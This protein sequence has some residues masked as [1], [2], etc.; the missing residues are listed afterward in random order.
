MV[1]A[2]PDG[3]A[4]DGAEIVVRLVGPFAVL[5]AGVAVAGA[6]LG[7]R[8]ARLLVKLLAVERGHLVPVNRIVDL[9]WVDEP[10]PRS[11]VENVATLVSRL[12]KV[13]GAAVVEGGRDEGY[14]LGRPPAVLVDLDEAE[15]W[16]GQA[17]ARLAAGEAG[18]AVAA[19]DRA[20]DLTASGVALEDEPDARWAEP[21][22]EQLISLL[23]KG[24]HVLA[25]AGLEAGDARRAAAVA[26]VAV[27]ADPYDEGACRLLMRALSAL[28]EPSR[29]LAVYAELRDRLAD[30]LGADPAAETR[31][32]HLGLLREEAPPDPAGPAERADPADPAASAVPGTRDRRRRPRVRVGDGAE[33]LGLVGRR[34]ELRSLRTRWNAAAAGTGSMVLVA[35]E[36][37]IGKTRLCQELVAIAAATGGTALQARCHEAE[38]SLFL[39]PVVD[40]VGAA[41]RTLP[42]DVTREATGDAVDSLASL[43]PDAVVVLGR[44]SSTARSSVQIEHRRAFEAV[45]GFVRR[46]AGRGPV[47]LL[48]DDLHLAGRETVQLLHYLARHCSASRLLVVAT[49]RAE[50][51]QDVFDLLADVGVRLD[52]PALPPEAVSQLAEAAGQAG[53]AESIQQR[54]GGHAL[55][56]VESLRALV[57]GEDG[58]PTSLQAAVLA[59]VRRAG[60]GVEEL[61]RAGAVLGSSFAAPIAARLLD[62][63]LPTVLACGEDAL[64]A[65]LL[66]ESGQDYEFAN[67][68][69]REVLYATTSAPRRSA[70]HARAADLLTDRAESV[71]LHAIAVGDWSRAAH[72]L[73]R[74]G[75]EALDSYA[76]GDAE[77]L[78]TRC[79]DVVAAAPDP[80]VRGRAL[81]GRAHAREA[82]ASYAEAIAD[83]EEAVS[84]ARATGDKRLEMLALRALGGEAPAALGLPLEEATAHLHHGLRLATSLGDRAMESDLLAWLAVLASNALRFDEA[85]DFGLR[86]VAAA[87]AAGKVEALA[88]ALDGRKTSV[89]Y[90]GEI[91]ELEQILAELEPLARQIGEPFRLHWVFFESGFPALAAGEW[92]S[93]AERFQLALETCR[94]N[95]QPAYETWHL[96]HL[97]W[98]ARLQGDDERAVELGQAAVALNHEVPH[99]WCGAAAAAL[100]GTTFLELG[101]VE[102]AVATL[103]L[104]RGLAEQE[105]S[106]AYLLRCLAPLAEATGSREILDQA[107]RLLSQV[108]TP[109]GSAWMGGDFTYLSIARAW[110]AAGEPAR[111]RAVLAPMLAVARRVPWVGPL[112]EG[113]LVDASAAAALGQADEARSLLAQAEEIAVRHGLVHVANAAAERLARC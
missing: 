98:L 68:L 65:R 100:L 95:G 49:V 93:A 57:A 72:A 36:A 27:S 87:R 89:A 106:E 51:G 20:M 75:E 10:A 44:T 104:G 38:R 58:V 24:R 97:G 79:L 37:G 82:R 9:L 83:L 88:A 29:A 2:A 80:D 61:L 16:V 50:E 25:T 71:A 18:L 15:R 96:A 45:T 78:L 46:L 62:E 11:P 3:A 108:A 86:A 4:P 41:F 7:S 5:R 13:L 42:P 43:V 81:L 101:R 111:A 39:Q 67:D 73:L 70:F 91:A 40:A 55:F 8:K 26:Q 1:P 66:V 35:G 17:E 54:T 74:A 69:V 34:D 107:D 85:V 112:A 32:L 31:E 6:D 92:A 76:A 12:R 33:L 28:G 109:S 60:P 113:C 52:V 102:E 47:L 14:R 53:Q 94:A 59:R 110:V 30:E 21:A 99:A 22:R 63:S 103:E 90:L 56:V 77:D 105:G 64:A 48:L 19:A 84:V 23:R